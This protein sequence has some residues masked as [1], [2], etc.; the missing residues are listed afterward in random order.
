[1]NSNTKFFPILYN[2][3]IM[4]VSYGMTE[5]LVHADISGSLDI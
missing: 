5:F 4:Y 3:K 2:H 1:M